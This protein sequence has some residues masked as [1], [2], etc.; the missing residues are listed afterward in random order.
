MG[1]DLDELERSVIE[2]KAEHALDVGCG[3]GHVTYRLAPRVTR[4]TAFDLSQDMLNAVRAN[5]L[6]RRFRNVDVRQGV[7]EHMPFAD[8]TF[9][10]AVSRFSAHHWRD[11][12]RGLSEAKRVLQTNGHAIFIDVVSPGRPAEDTFLQTLESLRDPSHVRDY[13]SGEWLSEL[14]QAGFRVTRCQMRTLR[15]DFDSWIERMRTPS[16][17]VDAIKSLQEMVSGEV[18]SQFQVEADG[19]FTVEVATFETAAD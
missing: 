6:E 12:R 2:M 16:T 19:S 9:D 15:L 11:L 4:V 13:S 7:V 5:S 3:G 8:A 18:R 10:L 1:E 17:H 14:S